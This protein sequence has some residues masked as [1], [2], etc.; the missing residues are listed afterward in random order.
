[1]I[2]VLQLPQ[3]PVQLLAAVPIMESEKGY[4]TRPTPHH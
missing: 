2:G 4:A 3:L 1:M